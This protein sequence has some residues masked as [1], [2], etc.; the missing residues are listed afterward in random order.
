MSRSSGFDTEWE[1]NACEEGYL[2]GL[3]TVLSILKKKEGKYMFP[4]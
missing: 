3:T 4:F 2:A 1:E